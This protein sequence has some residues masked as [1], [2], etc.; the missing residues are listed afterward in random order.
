M[1]FELFFEFSSQ[2]D[3][4]RKLR[5]AAL[6]HQEQRDGQHLEEE[7]EWGEGGEVRLISHS[8]SDVVIYI[9]WRET[10][11]ILGLQGHASGFTSA[12]QSLS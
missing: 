11:R 4:E 12:I 10:G 5:I 9:P 8:S 3:W 6:L 2:Q 1:S 7:G